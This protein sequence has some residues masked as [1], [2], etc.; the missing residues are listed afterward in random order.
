MS[1]K[2][3]KRKSH[4]AARRSL[5]SVSSRLN[6]DTD[7]SPCISAKQKKEF[8]QPYVDDLV[9]IKL[10]QNKKLLSNSYTKSK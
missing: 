6:E 1:P 2:N 7:L 9:Q 3:S 8:L 4:Y 5:Q 10:D